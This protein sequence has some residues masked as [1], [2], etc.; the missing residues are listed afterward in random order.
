MELVKNGELPLWNPYSY[1]GHP[2]LATLQPGVFYPLNL[3]L[4]VLPFDLAFNWLIVAHFVLSAVFMFFLLREFRA[5]FTASIISAITFMLSGYL[6]SV[7]NV[8][9]TLFSVSWVPLLL[10]LYIRAI[11]YN[12]T[13][14][15][16]LSGIVF[17]FMFTGGG[18]EVVIGII[19]FILFATLLP[20]TILLTH[21]YRI[22]TSTGRRIFLFSI[23]MFV[24]LILSGVQLLPF[25]ELTY[26]SIRAGGLSYSE[27]TVWSLDI[28]DFVQFFVPDPYGYGISDEKY[29]ANQS[30]LKTI[31]LGTIPFILSLFF[32]VERGRKTLP[33]VFI[34][35]LFLALA[36]GKNFA[37]Y[38]F[39]YTW[40]PVFNKI[41][42]PV[43]FL[44]L[45]VILIS[46]SSG[47]GYDSLRRGL[48][49]G[50]KTTSRC[51]VILLFLS[52][53][54][55][56]IFGALNFFDV[57]VKNYLIMNGIDYPEYNHVEINVF[58]TKRVLFF[59]LISGL[60][61]YT[62]LRSLKARKSLTVLVPLIL[63]VDLF[64][65]HSGY[66]VVTKTE[67][68]HKKGEV[69][70]YLLKDKTLFRFFT[71][72]RT[73][74]E[75]VEFP[76][77][78]PFDK[79]RMK[80]MNLDKERLTGYN[81]NYH[82]FDISGTNVMRRRDYTAFYD[83]L[84]FQRR[85]DSTNIL[86]ML[87]VKYVIS[88]PPIQSDE[89][90][91]LKI[92]GIEGVEDTEEL[93]ELKT[94]KIYENLNYLPRFFVVRRFRVVDSQ[95][96]YMKILAD[97]SFHP[98]KEVLLD[99][100]PWEG[101]KKMEDSDRDYRDTIRVREYRANS[102]TLEVELESPGI[103][104]ASEAYYPGW[105]VYVDGKEERILR[106]D[107]VLRGVALDKGRHTVRFVYMPVSFF[108]GAVM[109][110]LGVAGCIVYMARGWKKRDK[111]FS[112]RV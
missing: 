25:L 26:N 27:A 17:T 47:L 100:D 89:F 78:I 22:N 102:L 97:K 16:L 93:E 80:A 103:L 61:L 69:A 58:N 64:F 71:T 23:T 98:Q 9:S 94:L 30:W 3:F 33:F 32:F 84:T 95:D 24:F 2:L 39:L 20:E 73:L 67:D 28:K 88:I 76:E 77:D 46:I 91:L 66:Y 8:M 108:A 59:F 44:F 55:A 72:P 90:R 52:T 10:L 34:I 82:L 21:E 51:L 48:K 83:L 1:C 110:I 19:F 70:R 111:V 75:D 5:S 49:E 53:I 12:S 6:I 41:R 31:Y 38:K 81:L 105:K 4:I 112:G 74:K 50:E 87:N 99:L 92:I 15:A 36:M 86:P 104:V 96:E 43:K 63:T 14:H 13:F 37:I 65:A 35:T 109:T 56:I 68:Y 29:W 18:I 79:V 106:A 45:C 40:L 54:S 85:P 11:R 57:E 62:G 101:E 107:Y 60:L 42:Y 7:H